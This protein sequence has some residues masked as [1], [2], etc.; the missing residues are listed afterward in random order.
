MADW[1]LM[2]FLTSAENTIYQH[3]PDRLFLRL[4]FNVMPSGDQFLHK[5]VKNDSV[6][7][8]GIMNRGFALAAKDNYEIPL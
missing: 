4:F 2:D 3:L 5:L 8:L 7:N 1:V 6:T